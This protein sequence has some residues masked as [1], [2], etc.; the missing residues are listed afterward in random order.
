MSLNGAR[1]MLVDDHPMVR[2]GLRARLEKVSGIEV[3]AE[4]GSGPEAL[5]VLELARVN[6][7]LMDVGMKNMDGI[8]LTRQ[9]RGRPETARIPV[10]LLTTE[11][12]AEKKTPKLKKKKESNGSKIKEEKDEDGEEGREHKL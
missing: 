10:I 4:A 1:L 6:L 5:A 12:D 11:S 7:V 3:V 2:E 8:E 9:L